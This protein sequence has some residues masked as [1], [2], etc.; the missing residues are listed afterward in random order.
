MEVVGPWKECVAKASK[1]R[2]E[3][4]YKQLIEEAS[5]IVKNYGIYQDTNMSSEVNQKVSATISSML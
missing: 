3:L 1:F 5:K 2:A 4:M